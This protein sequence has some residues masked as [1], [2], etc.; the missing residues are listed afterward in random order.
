MPA[1]LHLLLGA[2]VCLEGLHQQQIGVSETWL[3]LTLSQMQVWQAKACLQGV[4]PQQIW[5]KANYRQVHVPAILHALLK[6]LVCLNNRLSPYSAYA[7]ATVSQCVEATNDKK[8]R[9]CFHT[10]R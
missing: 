9:E 5:P 10:G 2:L 6:W 1:A 3:S 4:R 8:P 7:L